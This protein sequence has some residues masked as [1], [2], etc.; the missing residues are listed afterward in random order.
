M[1]IQELGH[2]VRYVINLE[3]MGPVQSLNLEI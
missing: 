3:V 2:V 1:K